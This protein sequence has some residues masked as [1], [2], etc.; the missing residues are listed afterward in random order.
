[1]KCTLGIVLSCYS[2]PFLT[3]CQLCCVTFHGVR[4]S[5]AHRSLRLG[6]CSQVRVERETCHYWNEREQSAGCCFIVQKES[7]NAVITWALEILSN[8]ANC[9]Q[10]HDNSVLPLH[11]YHF[12]CLIYYGWYH[13]L[14]QASL[15]SAQF[16]ALL[17]ERWLSAKFSSGCVTG[18]GTEA[19]YLRLGLSVTVFAV[20]YQH[21]GHVYSRAML[22]DWVWTA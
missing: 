7:S 9:R 22:L 15:F 17:S 3:R 21:M 2:A 18:S 5:A 6:Y 16:L 10:S 12:K 8:P 14:L 19:G 11:N 13:Y 1:M 20:F 4:V